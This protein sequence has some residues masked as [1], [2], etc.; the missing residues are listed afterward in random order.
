MKNSLW[1]FGCSYTD[2]LKRMTEHDEKHSPNST[3][4]QYKNWKGGIVP[5]SWPKLL[6]KKINFKLHNKGH[7]SSS[8]YE[9]FSTFCKY[10]TQFKSGDLIILQWTHI[11]RFRCA[12]EDKLV[13]VSP[14]HLSSQFGFISNNT[15]EDFFVNRTNQAWSEEIWDWMDLINEFCKI[16]KVKIL[17]WTSDISLYVP[18][19]SIDK[20]IFIDDIELF[21]K[22]KIDK[23]IKYSIDLETNGKVTDGHCGEIGHQFMA[24]LIYE[25]IN[26]NNII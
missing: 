14:G 15:L 26:K 12:V 1:T 11:P 23:N 6:S 5:P 9:I 7:G 19:K 8:N 22:V 4:C 17:Y 2:D 3:F 13:S 16:K 20:F 21:S 18:Y 24:D 10:V 25:Y